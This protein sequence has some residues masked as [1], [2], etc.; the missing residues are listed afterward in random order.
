MYRTEEDGVDLFSIYEEGKHPDGGHPWV[1]ERLQVDEANWMCDMLNTNPE[2]AARLLAF[3]EANP[4]AS[5]AA[6]RMGFL[7]SE[8]ASF[9]SAQS[10]I[11]VVAADMKAGAK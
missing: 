2:T 8:G 7:M 10:S 5:W 9:E 6:T 4:D 11:V 3:D 1:M